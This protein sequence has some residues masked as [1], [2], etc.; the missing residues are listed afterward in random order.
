MFEMRSTG[1][2]IFFIISL[3]VIGLYVFFPLYW[4]IITALKSPS[5][6]FSRNPTFFPTRP[7]LNNFKNVLLDAR[8]RTYLKNS[9]FVSI[10]SSIFATLL[11]AY[12]GYSFSKYRYRGRKT[13]MYLILSS[14][15]FP[16]VV[17]L[18]SIYLIMRAFGLLDNYLSLILSYIT[19]TL[20]IGTWTLKSYFDQ[21]PNELIEAARV[22]GAGRFTI[23][24]RIMF[25]L[26]IP[27]MVSI[28]IYGFVWS[29]NDLIYSLTLI[30]S[31]NKRTLAPGLILNYLGEFQ[32]KWTEMMAASIMVSI[33]VAIM[34][35][36]LQ[37]F[38]VRGL[39]AGAVK[40]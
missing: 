6:A 38:F 3:I 1:F 16:Y 4:M 31:T 12:A 37:R 25:P 26:A 33:P 19:F 23:I 5:E 18:L 17:L 40:G 27:G 22:D 10:L 8:I 7:T 32:A 30:T 21:I 2:K 39:T 36:F 20:P 24:H 13:L 9:L 11:A 35:I 28:A 15:M 14:Q 29:W 34:F